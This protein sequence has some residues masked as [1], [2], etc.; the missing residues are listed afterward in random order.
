M[1]KS[2]F[3]DVA[4][5]CLNGDICNDSMQTHPEK[6]EN[7]CSICGAKVIDKCLNCNAPIRGA[8]Y[9]K[10][11]RYTTTDY[12][13]LT[14]TAQKVLAGV[15]IKCISETSIAPA[16]CNQCG[17]P[18]PWTQ[19]KLN[20]FQEIVDHLEDISPE[21]KD[22]LKIS[23]PDIIVQTPKT[24]LAAII[25]DNTLKK[26]SGFARVVFIKWIQDNAIPFLITLLKL[27]SK[28]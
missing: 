16:Y 2:L 9:S 19:S 20:A 28:T 15:D 11:I 8:Y 27:T 10:N 6:N 26:T 4:Q 1:N 23:F 22:Q 17:E 18:Y 25:I 21:L 24:E 12:N 7:F 3:Y 5:I 13:P 14:Q